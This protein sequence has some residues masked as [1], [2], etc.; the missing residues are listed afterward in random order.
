[1]QGH[2]DL[3]KYG[4]GWGPSGDRRRILYVGVRRAR[5]L[6]LYLFMVETGARGRDRSAAGLT[7]SIY[8][9]RAFP[10]ETVGC[11]ISIGTDGG[12]HT[13]EDARCDLHFCGRCL[14]RH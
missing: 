13:N 6:S 8:R 11:A 5:T 3:C 7:V 14:Y 10:P 4:G 1:M 12:K 9:R 2:I